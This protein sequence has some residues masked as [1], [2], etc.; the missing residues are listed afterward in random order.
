LPTTKK[1]GYVFIFLIAQII[2]YSLIQRLMSTHEYDFSVAL[3][4]K[5][6]FLPH[7]IWIYHTLIPAIIFTCVVLI[8]KK[9]AFMTAYFSCLVATSVLF[10]FYVLFPSFYPRGDLSSYYQSTSVWLVEMTRMIDSANNTFPSSHVT[11]SWLMFLSVSNSEIVKKRSFISVVY[12]LWALLVSFSTIVLKQHFIFDVISGMFLALISYSFIKKLMNTKLFT[13]MP[14]RGLANDAFAKTSQTMCLIKRVLGD[15]LIKIKI[16]DF[17]LEE[18]V[19]K[20]LSS[21]SC[22]VLL[23]S[24]KDS[25]E[26]MISLN[27]K[28]KGIIDALFISAI[29]K[30]SPT[31]PSLS[32]LTIESF[33]ILADT[34]G[35]KNKYKSSKTDAVVTADL[36][37]D[38]GLREPLHFQTHSRS[39]ATATILTVKKTIEYFIN[40]ELAMLALKRAVKDA[41]SRNRNDLLQKYILQ[42]SELVKNNLYI[43]LMKEKE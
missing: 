28:G 19:E 23:Y 41:K 8:K 30:F 15:E 29:E 6:P 35:R 36:F 33:S 42:M 5:I 34:T 22:S 11:F 17:T 25:K 10:I 7:F 21:V 32:K 27:A 26:E 13:Y 9:S 18:D 20:E 40:S 16:L 24:K 31:Y 38:S 12:F 1:A 37:V 39:L 2:I 14:E 3:D 4:E 43:D